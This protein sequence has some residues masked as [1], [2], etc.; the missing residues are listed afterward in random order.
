[1]A[2]A[3]ASDHVLMV[4]SVLWIDFVGELRI[5]CVVLSLVQKVD[6]LH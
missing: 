3:D 1:V 6:L 2:V 5:G 4:R